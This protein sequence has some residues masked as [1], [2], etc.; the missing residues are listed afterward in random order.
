MHIFC[1]VNIKT[2]TQGR[3][4]GWEIAVHSIGTC[5]WI[6]AWFFK[7]E[8]LFHAEHAHILVLREEVYGF[9]E[10]W[11]HK[12][13]VWIHD[14]HHWCGAS[15]YPHVVALTI[16]TIPAILYQYNIFSPQCLKFLKH[17]IAPSAIVVH[18]N[19]F[20]FRQRNVGILYDRS[21]AIIYVLLWVVGYNY[22]WDFF[23]CSFFIYSL[24]SIL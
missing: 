13:Y 2:R 4:D 18:N 6:G 20:Y 23:I 11:T 3:E 12:P 15:S 16:A 9:S 22:Y 7:S 5:K 1:Y 8:P 14:K 17:C 10:Y 21:Y 19:Q 24:L